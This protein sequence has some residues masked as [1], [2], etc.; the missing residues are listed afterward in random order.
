MPQGIVY[1]TNASEGTYMLRFSLP[2][3]L[4]GSTSEEFVYVVGMGRDH[5]ESRNIK[6]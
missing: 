3:Q 6:V 1:A 4:F 2:S 5:Q